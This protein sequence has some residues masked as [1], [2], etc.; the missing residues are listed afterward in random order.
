MSLSSLRHHT[1]ERATGA[2][3]PATTMLSDAILATTQRCTT[4]DT[5]SRSLLQRS[6][7][8]TEDMSNITIAA[9]EWHAD[10]PGRAPA[11]DYGDRLKSAPKPSQNLALFSRRGRRW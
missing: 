6:D 1:V 10:S 9:N 4:E 8:T 11:C 2:Q 5:A 3:P 7:E